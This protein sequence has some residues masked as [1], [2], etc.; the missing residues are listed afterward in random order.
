LD[1]HEKTKID[2]LRDWSREFFSNNTI[3]QVTWWSDLR[4]P[5]Q[6]DLAASKDKFVANEVDLL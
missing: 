5:T 3:K 6:E 1:S 4:E 2:E